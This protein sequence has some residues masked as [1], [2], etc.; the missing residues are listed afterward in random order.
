MEDIYSMCREEINLH[1]KLCGLNLGDEA[2]IPP[3]LCRFTGKHVSE[4]IRDQIIKIQARN[5]EYHDGHRV[6]LPA[7]LLKTIKNRK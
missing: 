7:T 5:T 2:S 1:L 4:S 6:P 3:Y